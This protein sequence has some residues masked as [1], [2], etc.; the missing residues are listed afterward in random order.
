[1]VIVLWMGLIPIYILFLH[2]G[3]AHQVK[4]DLQNCF[5]QILRA[6][7]PREE[8]MCKHCKKGFSGHET[9]GKGFLKAEVK[10][11]ERQKCL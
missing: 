11:F 7:G 1:M 2:L 9:E 8:R 4:M 6:G 5:N 10:S 3:R